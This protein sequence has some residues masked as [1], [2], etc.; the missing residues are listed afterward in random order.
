MAATATLNTEQNHR[1]VKF[2]KFTFIGNI[3]TTE[4]GAKTTHV[5]DG[6]LLHVVTSPSVTKVP[7]ANWDLTLLDSNLQDILAGGGLNR[8]SGSTQHKLQST[9]G[10]AAGSKLRFKVANAS[11]TGGGTVY[12]YIR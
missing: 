6:K 8:S 12:V 3:T 11:S 4:S 1:S 10:A 5:F 7:T 2:I 9:I